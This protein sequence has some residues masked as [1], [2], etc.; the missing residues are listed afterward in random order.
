[1]HI[2]FGEKTI[3]KKQVEKDNNFPKIINIFS[4]KNRKNQYGKWRSQ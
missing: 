1:M 2:I 4:K 3:E